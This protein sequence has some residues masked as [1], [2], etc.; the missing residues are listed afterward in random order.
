MKAISGLVLAICLVVSV[1]VLV[2]A[3]GGIVNGGPLGDLLPLA[4]I[5]GVLGAVGAVS[6]SYLRRSS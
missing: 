4:L 2:G 3:V 5:L 1:M 6:L